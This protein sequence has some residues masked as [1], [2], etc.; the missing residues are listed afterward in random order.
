MA[1]TRS[2]G[3]PVPEEV[4]YAA[5]P[6][7]VDTVSNHEQ[8]HVDGTI[9]GVVDGLT[10]ALH[11]QRESLDRAGRFHWVHW[12]VLMVSLV[13]TVS[14]WRLSS[15]SV[16][17]KAEAQFD[18]EAERV[19][20]LVQERMQKYEEGLRGGVAA[21]RANGGDMNHE[22]W[23]EFAESLRIDVK[24]PGINGIG[25][26][27]YV[28]GDELDEYLSG[29]R[30]LRPDYEIYPEHDEPEYLPI[31]YIEPADINAAAVGLDMAHET[32]RYEGIKAARDSGRAWITGPIVLVQDNGNTAGFLF[33]S[34]WYDTDEEPTTVEERREHFVGAVYAP[35]VVRKLM[36]GTLGREQRKVGFTIRDG[37]E[38]IYDENYPGSDHFDP[39]AIYERIVD[40]PMY[41]RTWTFTIRNDLAFREQT[42]NNEP[43]LILVGGL[44]LDG[45]LLVLFYLLTRSRRRAADFA[46]NLIDELSTN[47]RRLVDSNTELER[48][49]YIASHDLQ[50]P[51]R[52]I[53]DLVEYLEEDINAALPENADR[54]HIDHNLGRLRQQTAR[55][56]G[57]I[58]GIL[59]YSRIGTSPDD[60]EPHYIDFAEL[61][62]EIGE[63]MG[64]EPGQLVHTGLSSAAVPGSI[65]LLQ[66]AQNLVSNAFDHHHDPGSARVEVG[67][68]DGGNRLILTVSDNGPG[69]EK[70]FHT[71][72]F[73]LF[74]SVSGDAER[75]GIGL[76]IVKRIVE[77]RGG[78]VR[79]ESAIGQGTTFTVAWPLSSARLNLVENR[80]AMASDSQVDGVS[81]GEHG[82]VRV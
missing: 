71:R 21:I 45:V 40:V 13:V 73:D 55:M 4:R 82:V 48:F 16:E 33:F 5:R 81:E 59:D 43:M 18:R 9:D 34:P 79:V 26:I 51:L 24:Y 77:R 2:S 17:S 58:R 20:A 52:G 10:P 68:R 50:T 39:V 42:G 31:S 32:N 8:S 70:R 15:S 41:G 28:A 47:H 74:Q 53:G 11:R 63:Q 14:A 57:L 69:I 60:T 35:F 46:D 66:I 25:V 27:H 12:M 19:L 1:R 6:A 65:H 76:A 23:S 44:T 29:Q 49:A 61:V 78:S 7:S 67:F 62:T 30:R 37:E 64:L 56:T 75:S 72:I 80:V 54:S 38:V 3:Y 22:E 36:E